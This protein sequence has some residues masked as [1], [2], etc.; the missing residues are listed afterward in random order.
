MRNRRTKLEIMLGKNFSIY[1][2][3]GKKSIL[4]FS[5]SLC[6]LSFKYFYYCDKKILF[7]L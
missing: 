4:A 2:S 3:R 6:V 7:F 1:R 5:L